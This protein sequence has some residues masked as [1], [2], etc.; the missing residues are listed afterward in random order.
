M[1]K[2]LQVPFTS[3]QKQNNASI[4][5]MRKV[6]GRHFSVQKFLN[7]SWPCRQVW[8]PFQNVSANSEGFHFLRLMPAVRTIL[9]MRTMSESSALVFGHHSQHAY[10]SAHPAYLSLPCVEPYRPTTSRFCV[11]RFFFSK[12]WRVG[13]QRE[14]CETLKGM[15]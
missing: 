10:L 8:K 14:R 7:L 5:K 1:G 9:G 4:P 6:P 3:L 12:I 11:A 15:L 2:I 13:F